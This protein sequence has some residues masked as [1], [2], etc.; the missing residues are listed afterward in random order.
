MKKFTLLAAIAALTASSAIAVNPQQVEKARI[1]ANPADMTSVKHETVG[2][3]QDLRIVDGIEATEDGD[4]QVTI[5]VTPMYV[6]TYN[7]FYIGHAPY[8]YSVYRNPEAFTGIRNSVGFLNLTQGADA[9]SWTG[10]MVTGINADQTDYTYE[11]TTSN[12][13]NFFMELMPMKRYAYPILNAIVGSDEYTYTPQPS[14]GALY[15][16]GGSTLAWGYDNLAEGATEV[17]D[18]SEIFGVWPTTAPLTMKIDGT[19]YLASQRY[20]SF[21]IKRQGASDYDQLGERFS[22]NGSSTNWSKWDNEAQSIKNIVVNGFA[23]EIPEMPSPYKLSAMWAE[24]NK[25]EA[26][27]AITLPVNVYP[28][29]DGQTDFENP[30]GGGELNLNEGANTFDNMPVVELYGFSDGWA[31]TNPINVP[32]GMSIVVVIEGLEN[33]DLL[34][35]EIMASGSTEMDLSLIDVYD[36]IYPA[37]AHALV[38]CDYAPI[39]DGVAG[40]PE[41]TKLLLRD[42]SYYYGSTETM[43][44]APTDLYMFFDVEFPIVMNPVDRTANFEVEVPIE[45]GE[46][47]V[48][49]Y[50][51]YIIDSLIAENMVYT[52][53]SDWITFTT[54][55]DEAESLTNVTITA[56]A[57][58]EGETGRTG[59]V[60]FEGSAIDFH[61]T[62]KQGEEAG[63]EGIEV[64]PVAKGTKFYDLQGRQLQTAPAAGMYIESVDGKATKRIAR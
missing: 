6:P 10:G 17:T 11:F 28:I 57:L 53:A 36:Y 63:I 5:D 43:V 7:S 4:D 22:E 45:G 29:I 1:I 3:R 13:Q 16:C 21:M 30:I 34:S 48:P 26:S 27:A 2:V 15:H 38:T 56:A 44:V 39:V 12:A 46:V 8:I 52:M 47:V 62:V 61:I 14:P 58:P 31:T 64:R 37:H 41:N 20:V 60:A 18:W 19:E 24:L 54:A 35:F 25:V 50:C 51:D 59:Y 40:E 42:P 33:P 49:V 23:T 32:A 55:F 9:F